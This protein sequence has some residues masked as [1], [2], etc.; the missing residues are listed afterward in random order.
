MKFR[1]CQT[2]NSRLPKLPFLITLR[3]FLTKTKILDRR[4][5]L[6]NLTFIY[7]L[8]RYKHI[9]NRLAEVTCRTI[10]WV[11]RGSFLLP[12][13]LK[14]MSKTIVFDYNLKT[15]NQ[16]AFLDRCVSLSY[17]LSIALQGENI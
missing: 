10:N 16:K 13:F 5:T 11:G 7:L 12:S 15:F 1:V 6:V 2:K 17:L 9:T 4:A 14:S 8:Y 3:R